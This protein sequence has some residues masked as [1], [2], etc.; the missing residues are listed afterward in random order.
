MVK[1]HSLFL[2]LKILFFQFLK[3]GG[4][5]IE[6]NN[7]NNCNVMVGV[8]VSVGNMSIE[9][10]PSFLEVFGRTVQV[11]LYQINHFSFVL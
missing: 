11:N 2:I 5:S 9:R 4:F 1:K 10:A 6:I 8:R 7:T 3:P